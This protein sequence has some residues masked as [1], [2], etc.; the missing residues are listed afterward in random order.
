MFILETVRLRL[1]DMRLDD[2]AAFV[3][4][5]Q[6]ERYQRFYSEE[7]GRAQK[8]RELTRLFVEQA[9][10]RP[11]RA[12]QLAIE[13]KATNAL[14]GT[15][16]LRLESDQQAS[17]ECGMARHSQGRGLMQE[18]ASALAGFGFASLGVHRI[19]AETL[20]RNRAAI[21]LCSSLGMRQEAH[22]REHRYF[23]GQWWDTVVFALLR[24]EWSHQGRAA[25]T[26]PATGGSPHPPTGPTDE[27][28]CSPQ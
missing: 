4:I 24:S 2:E 26:E 5:T 17:M 23:K 1:R 25:P 18:A 22:F 19:Y 16:C 3:A 10:E 13:H 9:G 8:Y 28:A 27:S 11:R 20:S 21:R 14:I 7:D 15:V 6:D 12:Y